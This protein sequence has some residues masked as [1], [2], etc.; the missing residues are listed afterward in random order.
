MRAILDV[1]DKYI[2]CGPEKKIL[3]E[4]LRFHIEFKNNPQNVIDVEEA[5]LN[6]NKLD[7]AMRM[8]IYSIMNEHIKPSL[9]LCA[10]E[11]NVLLYMRYLHKLFPNSKFIYMV[12]DARAAVFSLIKQYKETLNQTSAIKHLLSWNS[13]NQMVKFECDQLGAG[14]CLLVK[15]ES[16]VQNVNKTLRQIVHF[17][18]VPWT[19]DLLKHEQFVGGRIAVSKIEWSTQQIKRPIYRDSLISWADYINYDLI[20]LYSRASMLLNLGYKVEIKNYDYLKNL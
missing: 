9:L 14:V 10:K 20:D 12:R 3:P 4:I 17:L 8:Y 15:Y 16:L 13:Y 7:N 2:S 11:P 1:H 6:E 19:D 5:G 18:N